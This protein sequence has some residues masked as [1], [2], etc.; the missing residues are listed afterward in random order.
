MSARLFRATC[1]TAAALA[2]LFTIATLPAQEEP[3]SLPETKAPPAPPAHPNNAYWVEHDKQLLVDFGGL[4][5]FKE[6]DVQLGPP[7]AG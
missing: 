7:A 3:A 4:G 6:A 2:G 1:L 5:R